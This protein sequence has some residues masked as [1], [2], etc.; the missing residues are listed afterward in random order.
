MEIP[1]LVE[2]LG[3]G[4]FRATMF[5]LSAEGSTA[6][7]AKQRVRDALDG[8]LASGATVTTVRVPIP[9]WEPEFPVPMTG[10]PEQDAITREWMHIMAENRRLADMDAYYDAALYPG[11]GHPDPLPVETPAGDNGSPSKP[12]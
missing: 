7:E 2:P 1:V 10:N 5:N 9:A 6:D 11:H 8:L 3:P 12:D 4:K